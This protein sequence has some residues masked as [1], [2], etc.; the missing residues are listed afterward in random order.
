M[1]LLILIFGGM[2]LETKA[3]ISAK[4]VELRGLEEEKQNLANDNNRIM[5]EIRKRLDEAEE[6]KEKNIILET[7]NEDLEKAN[8]DLKAVSGNFFGELKDLKK[9]VRDSSK[10][11]EKISNDNIILRDELKSAVAENADLIAENN[12]LTEKVENTLDAKDVFTVSSYDLWVNTSSFLGLNPEEVKMDDA[13]YYY[14]SVEKWQEI[15]DKDATNELPYLP[16]KRDCDNYSDNLKTKINEK[17][18]INGMTVVNGKLIDPKT[19]ELIGLHSM[20]VVFTKVG[21]INLFIIFEPQSD[22]YIPIFGPGKIFLEG[23]TFSGIENPIFQPT[24][25]RWN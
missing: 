10:A 4:E 19:G 12:Q 8:N 11:I 23:M 18:G 3:D 21:D 1:A 15:I 22:R 20:S 9:E 5:K 6:T 13:Y 2:Y 16:N 14:V 24:E 25:I 7:R 17:Y